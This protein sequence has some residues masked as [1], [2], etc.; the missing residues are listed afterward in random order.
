MDLSEPTARPGA[1]ILA[2]GAWTVSLA[3]IVAVDGTPGWRV[4]RALVVIAIGVGAVWI[5]RR[6]RRSSGFVALALGSVGIVVGG[7]LGIRFLAAGS[8]GVRSIGGLVLVAAGLVLVVAG[9]HEL[10]RDLGR[11]RLVAIPSLVLLVAVVVWTTFPA[12]LATNVPP[13]DRGSDTPAARGLVAEDVRFSAA[14]GIE[15]AAWYVPSRNGA[16]VVVRHGAGSTADDQLAQA[17]VLVAHGYGVLITDARGHGESDG[18]AMDFGWYG[19]DDVVGAVSFLADRPEVDADR[20]GVVGFSMGGEEA[21]GAIAADPRIRAVVAEGATGRTDADQA[22]FDDVYGARGRFQQALEWIEFT[23][24]DLL[25]DASRP[26]PL[27][28]AAAAAAPRPILLVVAG[29][30]ADEGHAAE[31]IHDG[32][33]GSVTIW[34]VPGAGHIEGFATAP[35][36]WES[37]VVGFLDDVLLSEPRR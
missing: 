4:A 36:E 2:L 18:R 19:D 28:D 6:H 25:T 21:I 12:V 13:I 30:V 29:G 15:L 27:A 5:E 37:R 32:A 10:T 17:S 35:D 8:I 20:I 24:T 11:G 14:D 7:V 26:T 16:A 22:W 3:A 33:P 23:L 31:H 9:G 34:E 1:S